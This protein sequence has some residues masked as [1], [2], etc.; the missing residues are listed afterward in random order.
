MNHS[1]SRSGGL[2]ATTSD[3]STLVAFLLMVLFGGGNA[4]AIRL[5]NFGLPPFWGVATRVATAM[6]IFWVIVLVRRTAL[7]RGRA[8]IGAMLY[9]TLLLVLGGGLLYWSLVRV[10]AGLGATILALSPLVT[11]FLAWGHGL[12]QLRWRGVVGAL[13]ATAGVAIGVAGGFGGSVHVMSVLAAVAATVAI[14]EAGV[15]IKLFPRGDSMA[16]NAVAMTTAAPILFVLSWLAGERWILPATPTTWAAFGYLV[17]IGSVVQFNLYL[18]VLSHWT[19][20]RASYAFLITPVA[21]VILAVLVLGEGISAGF[22]IGTALV[23]AGVWL[24]AIQSPPKEPE[25]ACPK[26]PTR[27][28]C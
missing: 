17:V 1:T 16:T 6:L 3:N 20:S 5:S 21:T 24:G 10:P 9:G 19:A 7:P 13:V 18:H 12:E 14:A 4:V 26:L 15:V 8:L 27:A 28:V 22:L 11:L 25:L 23:L 2:K